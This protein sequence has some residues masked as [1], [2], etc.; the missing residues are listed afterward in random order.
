MKSLK[1]LFSSLLLLL[2]VCQINQVQASEK[3]NLPIY[4]NII[5]ETSLGYKGA[6]LAGTIKLDQG[7]ILH[8]KDYKTRDDN[9]M[10]TWHA[11]DVIHLQAKIVDEALLLTAKRLNVSKN[12]SVEPYLVFDVVESSDKGLKIA[13]IQNNGEFVRLNDNSVWEFSFYNHFSTKK[14]KVGER[15]IVQGKGDKNSYEF[16]NLDVPVSLNSTTANATFVV[17]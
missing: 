3:V 4:Q 15:V 1:T 9:V 13:E 7:Q 16:I 14:W 11:G 8:I 6:L 10:N 12:E 2:V 17:H 5:S